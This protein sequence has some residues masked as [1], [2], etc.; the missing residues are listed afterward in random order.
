MVGNTRYSMQGCF[1]VQYVWSLSPNLPNKDCPGWSARLEVGRRKN[2]PSLA[3]A[4]RDLNYK[5][6]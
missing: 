2:G 1:S 6:G 3:M 5:L 4:W